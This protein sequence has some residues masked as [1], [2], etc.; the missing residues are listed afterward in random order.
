[1]LLLTA[2]ACVLSAFT[3]VLI[4]KLIVNPF[5]FLSYDFM[6][7]ENYIDQFLK[8]FIDEVKNLYHKNI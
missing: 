1:V 3:F 8:K 5:N 6:S 2:L 4:R 7:H